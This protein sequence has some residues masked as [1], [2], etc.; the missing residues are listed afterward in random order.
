MYWWLTISQA[1][2]LL[3]RLGGNFHNILF[4]LVLLVLLFLVFESNISFWLAFFPRNFPVVSLKV[5]E[6]WKVL[7]I[8]IQLCILLKFHIW[9][10]LSRMISISRFILTW[11]F[12]AFL[13][14]IK[15][16][17]IWI[18]PWSHTCSPY[19]RFCSSDIAEVRSCR[20]YS[21]RSR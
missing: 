19:S 20:C 17:R 5:D 18:G 15:S 21:C 3:K 11:R 7:N 2:W 16:H 14:G 9:T 8:L 10:N 13:S 12:V 4:Q 1:Y 6:T